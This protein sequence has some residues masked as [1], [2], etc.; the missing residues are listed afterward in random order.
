MQK[1]L[2]FSS[3]LKKANDIMK[4]NEYNFCNDESCL[5]GIQMR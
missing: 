4:S 3:E 5:K 2:F 1:A